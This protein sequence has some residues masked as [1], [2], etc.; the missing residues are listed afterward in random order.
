M[1]PHIAF[2][3]NRLVWPRTDMKMSNHF[4]GYHPVSIVIAIRVT[5]GRQ[6]YSQHGAPLLIKVPGRY[7]PRERIHSATCRPGAIGMLG[8]ID[9]RGRQNP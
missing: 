6:E 9:D 5:F 3:R 1:F 4:S 8:E 7:L 2:D